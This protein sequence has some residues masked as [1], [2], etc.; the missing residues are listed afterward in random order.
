M[1][2]APLLLASIVSIAAA[3]APEVKVPLISPFSYTLDQPILLVVFLAGAIIG[4]T[5]KFPLWSY[6]WTV[7]AIGSI[8]SLASVLSVSMLTNL[9]DPSYTQI[10]VVSTLIRLGGALLILAFAVSR[11]S[12]GLRYAFFVI[13]VSFAAGSVRMPTFSLFPMEPLI[14]PILINAYLI[15][16]TLVEL[17]IVMAMVMR[18]MTGDEFMQRRA[19][20]VLVA[21]VLLNAILTDWAF[22]LNSS[23]GTVISFVL[24]V[25]F[26]VSSKWVILSLSLLIT[27]GLAKG[28]IY[29]KRKMAPDLASEGETHAG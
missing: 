2:V 23:Y 25:A 21:V 24:P 9:N 29:W 10:G 6:S 27:W 14:N 22:Y 28:L 13:A 8:T 16:V 5:R 4:A 1:A 18:F 15:A 12:L 17:I 26:T 20:Y 19:V 7:M 11:S 3:V